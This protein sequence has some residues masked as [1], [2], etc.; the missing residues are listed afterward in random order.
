M[1]K[2]IAANE[3]NLPSVKNIILNYHDSIIRACDIDLLCGPFWLNDTIIGFYLEYLE[4]EKYNG[5]DICFVRPEVLQCLKF[6]QVNEFDIFL[7]P[8]GFKEKEFAI[9]PLNNC[10]VPDQIGG[11]HWSVLAYSKKEGSFFHIDSLSGSNESAAKQMTKNLCSYINV[12]YKLE[13]LPSA[14]QGNS[15]DCGVYV[16]KYCELIL[17][18]IIEEKR[19]S[20]VILTEVFDVPKKRYEVR[21]LIES[22]AK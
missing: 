18:N 9:M 4:R 11:S 10:E 14:Q 13:V 3:N 1:L 15:Y 2:V 21:R 22:L 19:I 8:L 12:P 16:L 20:N 7:A 5:S 17:K 6:S